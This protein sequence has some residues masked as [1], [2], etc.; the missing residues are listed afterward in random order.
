M[1]KNKF[2]AVCLAGAAVC[3]VG[4]LALGDGG[5]G[6]TSPEPTSTEKAYEKN[7]RYAACDDRNS[8]ECKLYEAEQ[9]MRE[10]CAEADAARARGDV[11]AS[12]FESQCSTARMSFENRGGRL[13]AYDAIPSAVSVSPG[14]GRI[15]TLD[16]VIIVDK[17]TGAQHPAPRTCYSAPV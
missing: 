11:M 8:A 7:P 10:R 2:L 16:E 13:S 9:R 17:A 5:D 12:L 1:N 14:Y 6:A 3:G 15:C 4:W